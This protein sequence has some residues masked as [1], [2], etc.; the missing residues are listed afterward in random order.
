MLTFNEPPA[1]RKE[2]WETVGHEL[3]DPELLA[4][5]FAV[6]L[7]RPQQLEEFL[8]LPDEERKRIG[9]A[10]LSSAETNRKFAIDNSV[11][12]TGGAASGKTTLAL[13]LVDTFRYMA[14]TPSGKL[15]NK[16]YHVTGVSSSSMEMQERYLEEYFFNRSQGMLTMLANL[17][18]LRT[19]QRLSEGQIIIGGIM[20]SL[21]T[22]CAYTHHYEVDEQTGEFKLPDSIFK[23]LALTMQ[24][25]APRFLVYV[26]APFSIRKMRARMQA[27]EHEYELRKREVPFQFDE[28]L[29]SLS[30]HTMRKLAQ[31]ACENGQ[32][33][34]L[35]YYPTERCEKQDLPGFIPIT[36]FHELTNFIQAHQD[37]R[38]LQN[39]MRR[40]DD[41]WG[42]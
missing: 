15:K 17:T 7:L 10:I 28:V 39:Y 37:H 13:E 41:T 38:A 32:Q 25:W 26:D 9:L 5:E 30:I 35:I 21:I 2:V 29:R 23:T 19:E 31:E 40:L 36:A 18:A 12:L 42:D 16:H 6:A 4:A 1:V 27:I 34:F 11:L 14:H 8:P 3:F 22:L 24:H 33:Q 20:Q